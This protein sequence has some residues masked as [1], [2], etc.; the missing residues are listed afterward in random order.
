MNLNFSKNKTLLDEMH[1]NE[2]VRT[3]LAPSFVHLGL[4][5]Q[6]VL[7]KGYELAGQNCCTV[8]FGPCTGETS[9]VSLAELGCKYVLVGHSERRNNFYETDEDVNKKVLAVQRNFMTPILLIGESKKLAIDDAIGVTLNQLKVAMG[10]ATAN[11]IVAYEPNW[12]IGTNRSENVDDIEKTLSSIKVTMKD[13]FGDDIAQKIPL[14]YGAG[15]A[16]EQV[17]Q[18]LSITD[19]DGLVVGTLGLDSSKLNQALSR[20]AE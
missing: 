16:L 3:I 8:D 18:L 20:L 15:V 17:D 14:L 19:L 11:L 12:S 2:H 5:A 10:H 13:R 7:L 1:P 4:L 6:E 9:P